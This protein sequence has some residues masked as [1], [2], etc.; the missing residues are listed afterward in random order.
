ML[1]AGFIE[2]FIVLLAGAIPVIAVALIA[3]AGG[4]EG[5]VPILI[6]LGLAAIVVAILSAWLCFG[7]ELATVRIAYDGRSPYTALF[8][9]LGATVFQRPWRS[10]LSAVILVLLAGGG[11]LMIA[12]LGELPPSPALRTVITFG[13]GGAGSI[14]IESLSAAFLIA[15]DVDIAIRREGLDLA[16]TLDVGALS[17]PLG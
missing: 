7:Y 14:L 9:S 3:T 15:Y 6:V 1:V 12:L 5:T 4:G 13:L 2:F 17:A 16:A 11:S 10:L 8:S